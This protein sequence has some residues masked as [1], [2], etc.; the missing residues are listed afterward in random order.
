MKNAIRSE[1]LKI[2]TVRS[3]QVMMLLAFFAMPLIA[4]LVASFA[5]EPSMEATLGGRLLSTILLGCLGALVVGQE[6]RFGTIRTS[7]TA[8][9]RRGQLLAAKL[10]VLLGI[11]VAVTVIGQAV[12]V[13]IGLTSDFARDNWTTS[14][15]QF[16]QGLTVTVGVAMAYVLV[17]SALALLFRTPIGAI[18]ALLV[19]PLIGEILI[20]IVLALIDDDL[21][22]WLPFAG[23]SMWMSLEDAPEV[24]WFQGPMVLVVLTIGMV[25]FAWQMFD[26]RDA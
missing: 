26:K 21:P 14:G 20:G 7:L 4:V 22:N 23:G 9:P 15:A 16:W 12:S 25:V 8:V 17:G 18:V 2:T 10:A 6:F 3:S 5:D 1:W 13:L 11:T 24:R 19:W